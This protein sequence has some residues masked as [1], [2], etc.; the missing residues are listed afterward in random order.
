MKTILKFGWGALLVLLGGGL[1]AW[2]GYN[3]FVEMQP[4]AEGRS[5]IIPSLFGGAMLISGILR[6]RSAF[7]SQSQTGA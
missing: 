6:I 2:I 7:R 4:Q 3:T 5:P 1:L